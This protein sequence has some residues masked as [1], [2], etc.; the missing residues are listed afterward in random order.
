[1]AVMSKIR[2]RGLRL[3]SCELCDWLADV[4][5]IK[6]TDTINAAYSWQ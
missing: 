6:M 5:V 2:V 4:S 1:M 3:M